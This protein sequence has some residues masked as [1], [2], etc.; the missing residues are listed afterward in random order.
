MG[1]MFPDARDRR[2]MASAMEEAHAV[3]DR[4]GA[5]VVALLVPSI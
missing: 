2:L 4:G 1:K 3:L 5:G